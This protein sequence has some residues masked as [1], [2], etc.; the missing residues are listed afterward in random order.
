MLNAIKLVAFFFAG[1]ITLLPVSADA[2]CSKT[3]DASGEWEIRQGRT[4][5]KLNIKQSGSALSGT[6]ARDVRIG[7]KGL[8]G[9]VTGDTGG[10]DFSIG[11]D[12]SDGGFSIYR[13]IVS[14]TGKLEGEVFA[15]G[16]VKTGEK[17]YGEQPL[18]CG[19]TPGK[20]RGNLTSGKLSATANAQPGQ[21]TGSLVR[22]PFVVA[23][24]S[25]FQP[26]YNPVGFVVLQWD[27][28]PDHPNAELWVK[29]NNSRERVLFVKQP[30]GGQQVQVQ[31][32]T[33]YTYVLM[34]GRNVLATT[35]FAAQ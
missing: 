12:W 4:L 1:A 29:Y 28:G 25:Y 15:R 21:A 22:G 30:K 33:V 5:V 16:N 17:W 6:A 32:G 13:A 2:Q 10:N 14:S 9:K 24:Q 35:T 31:R 18:T 19:W 8:Q 11:I 23:S 20:S 34:D 26:P 3:W 7:T 27:A